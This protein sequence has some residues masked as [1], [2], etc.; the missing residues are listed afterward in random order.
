MVIEIEAQRARWRRNKANQRRRMKPEPR[1]LSYCLVRRV[2]DERRRRIS[3]GIRSGHNIRSYMFFKDESFAKAISF[4]AHVWAAETLISA[5]YGSTA[6][7]PTCVARFLCATGKSHGY[8]EES[9]RKTVSKARDRIRILETDEKWRE[10]VWE[11]FHS[12]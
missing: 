7:T 3:A 12:I 1:P 6:V 2:L 11:P 4:A 8:T 10:C 5:Q 9:L